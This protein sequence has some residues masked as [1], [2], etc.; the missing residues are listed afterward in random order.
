LQDRQHCV[1]LKPEGLK[2]QRPANHMTWREAAQVS[3]GV[4]STPQFHG[5]HGLLQKPA[6]LAEAALNDSAQVER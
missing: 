3:S 4:E 5:S 6:L 1:A 2:Q